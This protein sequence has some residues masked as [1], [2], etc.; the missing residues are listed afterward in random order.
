M[1]G[2]CDGDDHMWCIRLPNVKAG[3]E[4]PK[5]S[6]DGNLTPVCAQNTN[7][8]QDIKQTQNCPPYLG[9][10]GPGLHDEAENT[11]ARAAHG[12]S[13]QKLVLERLGLSLKSIRKPRLPIMPV[14]EAVLKFG[15][16]DALVL[17]V[18]GSTC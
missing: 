1:L 12:K 8:H 4:T 16:W 17:F 10:L 2:Y 6:I 7:K 18:Q 13:A 11:V 15:N 5:L 9:A 3:L 14:R